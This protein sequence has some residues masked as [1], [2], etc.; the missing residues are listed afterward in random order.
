MPTSVPLF[1]VSSANGMLNTLKTNGG[2][3]YTV[4]G[5]RTSFQEYVAAE[6]TFPDDLADRC[7][8][9]EQRGKVRRAYQRDDLLPK[10]RLIM[11]AWSDF[12]AG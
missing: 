8:A 1:K 9:H 6:T 12:V 2:N 4:H 3:G 7:I 5:F 11:T 10:R